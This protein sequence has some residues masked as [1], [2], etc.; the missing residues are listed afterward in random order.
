MLTH[1]SCIYSPLLFISVMN[2]VISSKSKST[3]PVRLQNI[4]FH[5]HVQVSIDM[6]LFFLNLDLNAF[7]DTLLIQAISEKHQNYSTS[8]A[9]KTSFKF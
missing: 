1:T 6:A 4:V 8:L 2:L 7:L 9:L 3:F 5:S